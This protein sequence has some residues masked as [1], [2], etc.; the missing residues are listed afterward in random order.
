MRSCLL[1]YDERGYLLVPSQVAQACFP[2]D[3]L[4]ALPKQGEI[5]LVPLR[6]AAAGGLLLKQRNAAGDRSVLLWEQLPPG[7]KA[8]KW[9][10]FWD[11]AN[12]AL[13]VAFGAGEHA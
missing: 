10:A 1:D 7:T 12:G 8:G 9:P 2:N 13:R 11:E 6:G 4:V 5:W 3:V